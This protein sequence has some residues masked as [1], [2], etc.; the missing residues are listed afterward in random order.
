MTKV[1]EIIDASWA[2]DQPITL[3]FQT[4]CGARLEDTLVGVR[5]ERR[6]DAD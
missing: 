5:Y 1:A 4:G 2:S 3:I 6:R